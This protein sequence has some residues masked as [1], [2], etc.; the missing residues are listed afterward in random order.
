M[1]EDRLTLIRTTAQAFVPFYSEAMQQSLTGSGL[2]GPAWYVSYL[3]HGLGTDSISAE[4]YHTMHPYTNIERQR[5][6]LQECMHNGV[7]EPA[8]NGVYALTEHGKG[9]LHNFLESAAEIIA[10]L[11]PL[12]ESELSYIADLL[13]DIVATTEAA[14]LP[15]EKP[16]LE[17]SRRVAASRTTP[18][19]VR[20]D[21]YLTDLQQ[22]RDSAHIAAWQPLNVEGYVWESFVKVCLGEADSAESLSDLLSETSGHT[23]ADYAQ[24]LV[25][26]KKKHW[27]DAI[28]RHYEPSELGQ[29]IF[30]EVEAKTDDYYYVGWDALNTSQTD[31][32]IALLQQLRDNLQAE[33]S[34]SVV[35]A[36]H[37]LYGLLGDVANYLGQA[38]NPATQA[39]MV[40]LDMD[41]P[42][43]LFSL[44]LVM[45]FDPEPTYDALLQRRYPYGTTARWQ[46]AFG[47]L[48][49]RDLL[50]RSGDAGYVV[51]DDGRAIVDT[52]TTAFYTSL[53]AVEAQIADQMPTTELQQLVTWLQQI[54]AECRQAPTPPGSFCI[55]HS[56]SR[57]HSYREDAPLLGK[58]DQ[59]LDDFNAFRDDAHLATFAAYPIAGHG[60]ELFSKMWQG[61]VDSAEEMAEKMAFRGHSAESY[62]LQLD[63]L[64]KLGWVKPDGY[65]NY[66][67]TRNGKLIRDSAETQ[68]NRYFYAPWTILDNATTDQLRQA[69]IKLAVALKSTL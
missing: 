41:D 51:T 45:S 33:Y 34:D 17:A 26:L 6:I 65:G 1:T 20:I 69:L 7:L 59:A 23:P 36:R 18:P 3:A 24:A 16:H 60:W 52:I 38:T 10:P 68:T 56:L 48:A 12:D 53:Y 57:Y 30:A 28:D 25:L 35:E 58:V 4:Q 66:D 32:L 9:G 63:D 5:T 13:A 22:Y 8:D 67:V 29:R 49:E 27:L 62:Q 19:I 64:T 21:Q 15:K 54:T 43:L 2:T 50:T 44:I 14:P 37:D 11:Q 31:E 61:D 55:D 39:K 42:G 46:K 47:T 40:E